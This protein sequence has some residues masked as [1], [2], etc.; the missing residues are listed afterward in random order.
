MGSN[1]AVQEA[2][3]PDRIYMTRSALQLIQAEANRHSDN[4]QSEN[5]TGGILVGRRLTGV[6]RVELLIAA[7]TGPGASAYH[8]PVEFNPDVD[9]VNR[10]L[11][12]YH[13]LYPSM[14]YIGTWH[15]HPLTYQTFSE[16]DVYTAHKLFH[17]AAYKMDEIVNPIVWV[18]SGGF[19]IRYYYMSRAMAARGERFVE[20]PPTKVQEIDDNHDL[21]IK[22]QRREDAGAIPECIDDE[23]RR[24]AW[25]GYQVELKQHEQEYF[26]T[27]RLPDRPDL[28][29]HLVAPAGYPQEPPSLF[30]E[31]QGQEIAAGDGGIIKQWRSAAVQ[32]H[33]ADVVAGV[34]ANLAAPPPLPPPTAPSNENPQERGEEP[35]ARVGQRRRIRFLA[36]VAG[37]GLLLAAIGLGVWWFLLA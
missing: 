9:Y 2:P 11:K 1:P 10:K 14:D 23:Y 19:T 35:D 21:V 18:G 29:L 30:V 7:A 28:A 16:G 15:K 12:E 36:V 27:V 3:L 31:Q 22:E 5:E 34:I 20:I 24:L 25:Q 37:F 4:P 17:D 6:N 32:P 33:L 26:F 8:N 13:A